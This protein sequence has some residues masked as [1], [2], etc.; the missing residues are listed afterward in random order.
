LFVIRWLSLGYPLDASPTRNQ[1]QFA[2]VFPDV[3]DVRFSRAV[4]FAFRSRSIIAPILRIAVE[5]GSDR[6]PGVGSTPSVG[7]RHVGACLVLSNAHAVVAGRTFPAG[8]R[9]SASAAGSLL[10]SHYP[11]DTWACCVLCVVQAIT[12][13]ALLLCLVPRL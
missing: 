12:R 8:E 3:A 2:S 11:N 6:P 7:N 9:G 4:G 5:S 13:V 1:A 10:S